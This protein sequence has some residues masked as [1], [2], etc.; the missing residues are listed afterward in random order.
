MVLRT[1]ARPCYPVLICECNFEFPARLRSF[2]LSGEDGDV[3]RLVAVYKHVYVLVT[4]SSWLFFLNTFVKNMGLTRSA[5]RL[6]TMACDQ[7]TYRQS[8][9]TKRQPPAIGLCE[10]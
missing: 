8:A 3:C 5:T 6:T 10:L 7:S 2:I 9:A 1:K 4:C